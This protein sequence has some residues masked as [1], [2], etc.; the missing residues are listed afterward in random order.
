LILFGS[1]LRDRL[2]GD[3]AGID[4]VVGAK[5]SPL[6]LILSAV[7]QAD[8][9][10]GNIKLEEAD[11]LRKNPM[12]RSVVP[13][14]MGDNYRRFRILGTEHSYPQRFRAELAEGK[15]WAAKSMEVTLGAEVARA[16]GLQVGQ[17]FAGAHGLG[18]PGP[19]GATHANP[20]TVVGILKPTGRVVDRLVLASIE[21]VWHI[22]GDHAVEEHHDSDEAADHDDDKEE[23][24]RVGEREL[25]ALLV[26][27]RSPVAAQM[28]PR[29]INRDTAMQAASPAAEMARLTAM[30]GVGLDT[31]RGF[32]LLLIATAGLGVFIALYNALQD[33]RY[34]LAVMR[35]LGAS[36]GKLFGQVLLEGLLMAGLGTLLGLLIGHGVTEIL[37]AGLQ[38][39]REMGLTGIAWQSE[40]FYVLALGLGVGALAAILPALQVFRVDIAKTL[41][42]R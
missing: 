26:S 28:L 23:H 33:R 41:T 22:H 34:D 42:N 37:G 18:G 25:T 27:Y 20:Y 32:G 1:Q 9:P 24:E 21:S 8:I 31:L 19:D 13:L 30:L 2:A 5:G 29:S 14:A 36:A 15:L 16:T 10:T 35:S 11:K 12:V 7:Y 6:Q 38:Q 4:M 39:A 3:L 17:Q 40:E